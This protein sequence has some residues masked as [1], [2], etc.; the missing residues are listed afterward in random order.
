MCLRLQSDI[1][2]LRTAHR[3]V[4]SH[5]PIRVRLLAVDETDKIQDVVT[6]KSNVF[7]SRSSFST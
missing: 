1:A 7:I 4:R 2:N 6:T 5:T 3:V